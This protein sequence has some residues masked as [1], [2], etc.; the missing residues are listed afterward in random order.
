MLAEHGALGATRLRR[1][2]NPRLQVSLE[3]QRSA[4]TGSDCCFSSARESA[5]VCVCVCVCVCY[6]QLGHGV[7]VLAAPRLLPAP[8]AVFQTRQQT[9]LTALQLQQTHTPLITHTLQLVNLQHTT[10]ESHPLA[11]TLAP[12]L[13]LRLTGP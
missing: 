10:P 7:C 4:A 8:P 2:E 3:R 6:L 9:L 13:A 11:S 1:E 5:R 12:A